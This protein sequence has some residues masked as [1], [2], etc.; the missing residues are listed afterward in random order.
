[1]TTPQIKN[2]IGEVW[3]NKRAARAAR[4]YEQVRAVICKTTTPNHRIHR[5]DEYPSI[6]PSIPSSVLYLFW[7][8]SD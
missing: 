3:K 8:R 1:M 5:P 6:Q 2:L 4:S 7:Q